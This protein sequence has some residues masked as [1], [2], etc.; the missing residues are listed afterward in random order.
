MNLKFPYQLTTFI[1]D[2]PNIDEPVYQGEH[3]WYPQIALKRRFNVVGFS[4]DEL[5]EMILNYC[6]SRTP[7]LVKTGQL[8][9]PEDMPVKVVEVNDIDGYLVDFHNDFISFMGDAIS[10]RFPE[11]DGANYFPHITAE[12]NGEMVI[13]DKELTDKVFEINRIYLLK[14]VNDANSIAYTIFDL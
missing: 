1:N 12:F 10:S 13:D 3:G 6:N 4:E 14:D 8:L 2:E 11:R 7:F 9:K 5:I